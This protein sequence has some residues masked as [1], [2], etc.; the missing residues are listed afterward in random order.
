MFEGDGKRLHQVS[1]VLC[2]DSIQWL[3]LLRFMVLVVILYLGFLTTFS[4]VG[5]EHFVSTSSS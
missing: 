4:L 2:Y 3:T 1:P 5:R